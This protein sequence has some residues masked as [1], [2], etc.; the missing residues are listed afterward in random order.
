MNSNLKLS[1]KELETVLAI[2]SEL[3]KIPYDKLNCFLGSMTITD[4]YQLYRK[5]KDWYMKKE[6]INPP[7][8]WDG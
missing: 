1:E 8:E 7:S 5:L 4:M 2:T 6:N 3:M